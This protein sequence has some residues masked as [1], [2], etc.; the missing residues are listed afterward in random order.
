[1]FH[2]L[3]TIIIRNLKYPLYLPSV[4]KAGR[5]QEILP[6]PTVSHFMK[7]CSAVIHSLMQTEGLG[8]LDGRSARFGTRHKDRNCRFEAAPQALL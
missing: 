1:M 7:I 4:T 8:A 6:K 3:Y 5:C 2:F